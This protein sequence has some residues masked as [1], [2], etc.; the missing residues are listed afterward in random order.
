MKPTL[1]GVGATHHGTS[2]LGIATLGRR[3]SGTPQP[4]LT[5]MY[6]PRATSIAL[7]ALDPE[8]SPTVTCA[9]NPWFSGSGSR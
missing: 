6:S 1:I 4:P 5:M 8:G 9:F 3:A 7:R 2:L